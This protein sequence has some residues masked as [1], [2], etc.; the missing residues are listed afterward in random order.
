MSGQAV[1]ERVQRALEGLH[2]A[3]SELSSESLYSLSQDD[4]LEVL[5]SF[6]SVRRRLPTV[7]HVLVGELEARS[8][9]VMVGARNAQAVLREVLRLSPS[10]AAGRVRAAERLGARETVTGQVLPPAFPVVAAAQAVGAVSAEQAR[11]ITTTIEELP[12]TVRTEHGESVEQ[13]LVAEASRFDPTVLGKLGRHLQAVLDPDGTLASDED[14]LQRRC[15]TLTHNRDGS[16]D[17]RAHLTATT[18]ARLQAALLPLAA[19]RPCDEQ[20]DGRTATQRL[21]DAL[22]QA[23]G[24]LLRSGQ[25]P[26]SGGTPATVLVTMTLSELESRTGL[27]TTG[28][29]GTITVTQALRLA[30]EA[31]V[32]PVVVGTDGVLGYGRSRRIATAAQRRALAAR[33][34]GCVFPGCDH[35]PDWCEAHHVIP[36]ESGG[37]TDLDNLALLCDHHHDNHQ[38]AGWRFVMRHG[39]PWAIPPPWTDPDQ[40]PIRNTMHDLAP[41]G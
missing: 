1:A 18:L 10:E 17:L 38:K 36:W 33:D 9:A 3:L 6:E 34:R 32:I 41:V 8:V 25:L 4:L 40:T 21:H 23:A 20:R 31:E 12:A 19:P 13:T 24:M 26:A 5:R 30:G 16:G 37:R 2:S 22:G 15:A 28:H 27:V 39:R 14:Q 11:V 7:D 29:G 35:P